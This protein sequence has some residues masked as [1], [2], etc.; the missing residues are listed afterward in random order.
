MGYSEERKAYKLY[1]PITNKI[2]I[3]RDV[4]FDEGGVH[5]HQKGHVEKPKSV[6]DNDIIVDN[7]NENPTNGSISRSP[8]PPRSPS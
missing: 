7:D 2:L 8:S 3:S 4:I 6:L 5:G 1:N